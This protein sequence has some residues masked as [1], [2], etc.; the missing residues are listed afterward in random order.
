MKYEWDSKKNENN[1]K[2]HGISFENAKKVFD[3][4]LQLSIVDVRFSYFE[5]R[6]IT[7]GKADEE[8]LIV[9]ANIYYNEEEII[10]IISARKATTKERKQY[11]E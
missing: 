4:P 8:K 11:E 6:W 7:M 2:K 9:V 3:D 10:R 5:E 1:K